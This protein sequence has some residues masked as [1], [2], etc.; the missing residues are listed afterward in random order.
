MNDVKLFGTLTKDPEIRH[1]EGEGGYD[2]ARFTLRVEQSMRDDGKTF[3]NN[4]S[5]VAFRKTAELVEKYLKKDMAVLVCAHIH[6]GSYT[7]RNG[8]TVFS[9]SIVADKFEI[10]SGAE[11]KEPEAFQ[12]MQE[13]TEDYFVSENEY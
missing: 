2:M 6:A 3:A 5:L 1:A 12:A 10:V 7:T 8:D 4:V 13:G 11:L 9:Q